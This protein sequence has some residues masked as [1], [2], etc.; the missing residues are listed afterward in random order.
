MDVKRERP[1]TYYDCSRYEPSYKIG[2]EVLFFNPTIN[3]VETRKFT[4]CFRGRYIIVE[5]KNNLNFKVE[6]KKTRKLLSSIMTG[7][8]NIKHKKSHSRLSL[9]ETKN[10]S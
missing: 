8:E 5:I 4:S 6:D 2:A 1:K 3:K 7:W 9:S 10:N